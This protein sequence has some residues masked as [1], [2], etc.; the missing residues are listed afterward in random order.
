MRKKDFPFKEKKSRRGF[1]LIELLVVIS[2]IGLL[3]ALI[4]VNFNAARER[5]RDVQRKSDL[6]QTKKALRLYYNDNNLYPET[7][8][9]SKI[10]ACGNPA[11]TTFEWES[12]FV[13]GSMVYMKLLPQDPA[14]QGGT[15]TYQYTQKSEGQDF[16]LWAT[17]ENKSDED[18]ARSQLR[19][20]GCTVG[21][22]DYVVCAD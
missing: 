7:G 8:G 15:P 1:T 10:K 3:S 22:D 12:Q 14:E 5:A 16:C 20:S 17:L 11:T 21:A 6:D 19:C 2:I 18:V 13:C 9:G 4:I